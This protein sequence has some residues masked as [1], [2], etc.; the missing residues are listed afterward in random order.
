MFIWWEAAPTAAQ[1]KIDFACTHVDDCESTTASKSNT[2][3]RR[4]LQM[5]IKSGCCVH[6][7]IAFCSDDQY[8]R[9]VSLC[10][11]SR[12]SFNI[13]GGRSHWDSGWGR[14]CTSTAQ[15]T[16]LPNLAEIDIIPDQP[17]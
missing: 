3:T 15:S 11:V 10:G 7:G 4:D 16:A 14:I 6:E 5:Q 17:D 9:E 12:L 13:Y 8:V 1:P 2:R